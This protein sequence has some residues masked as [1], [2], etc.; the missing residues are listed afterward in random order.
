MLTV[1][2]SLSSLYRYNHL[3]LYYCGPIIL[4][5][6]GILFL[7]SQDFVILRGSCKI[8][9][10]QILKGLNSFWYFLP[11]NNFIFQKKKFIFFSNSANKTINKYCNLK[12]VCIISPVDYLYSECC[13]CVDMCPKPNI[14][15]H[16]LSKKS[17]VEDLVGNSPQLFQVEDLYSETHTTLELEDDF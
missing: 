2:I 3:P 1:N 5:P 7:V 4:L 15:I 12:S 17:H 13:S 14:T 8:W 11:Q 6:S 9:K 16:E 10:R